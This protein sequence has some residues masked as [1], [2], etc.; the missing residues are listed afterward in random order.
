MCTVTKKELID[1]VCE[2]TG[3]KRAEVRDIVQAFLDQIVHQVGEGHRI[4]FRD[5]GVFEVKDRAPRTAQNP[6]TLV[7]VKVPQRR[8]VKFKVGRLM[9]D[10]LERAIGLHAMD[11]PVVL[12]AALDPIT[13]S[14]SPE[15]TK[16]PE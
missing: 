12:E 11:E 3:R 6:K 10:R 1:Q 15:T 8:T 13:P 9:R 5:F 16:N 7:P 2:R 14:G 4:E